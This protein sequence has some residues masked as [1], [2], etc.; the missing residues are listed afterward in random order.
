VSTKTT[1][2]TTQFNGLKYLVLF[3]T[4]IFDLIL[5][6]ESKFNCTFDLFRF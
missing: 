6:P 1:E 2:A 4:D 5:P 3:S